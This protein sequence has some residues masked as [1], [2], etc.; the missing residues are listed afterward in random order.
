VPRLPCGAVALN[1]A[2][3]LVLTTVGVRG[4][5]REQLRAAGCDMDVV[6]Q[7]AQAGYLG[8]RY[9]DKPQE[10]GRS[11]FPEAREWDYV[12]TSEGAHAAGLDPDELL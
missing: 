4:A 5:D 9:Y 7:L 6:L 8:K 3:Q 11:R 2:Q 12:L 10:T 1:D